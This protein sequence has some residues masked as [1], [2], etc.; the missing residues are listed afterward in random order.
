MAINKGDFVELEYTGKLEDGT[1]FDTTDEA[2]AKEAGMQNPD[3]KYGPVKICIGENHVVAGLDSQLE[4]KEPGNEYTINVPPEKGFGKKDAKQIQLISTSKFKKENVNPAPGL[5]VNIDGTVGVIKSVSGGRTLVDFNHPLSGQNLTYEVRVKRVVE[6]DAEKI[7]SLLEVRLGLENFDVEVKEGRAVI[8]T[9]KET[10]IPPE[11]EK[12]ISEEIKKLV[13]SVKE[14]EFRVKQE[15]K[16]DQKPEAE[17]K[18]AGNTKDQESK[19]E[20]NMQGDAESG[21]KPEKGSE[22][23]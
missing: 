19:A 10:G 20:D 23:S 15:Q 7:R 4:G 13:P 9:E 11:I 2:V 1:V 3:A 22:G 5:Q 8:T 16:K 6:D 12:M 21:R 17:E 18:E 14:V